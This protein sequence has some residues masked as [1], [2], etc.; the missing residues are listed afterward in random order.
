MNVSEPYAGPVRDEPL[1]VELHNTLFA[2]GGELV[3]GLADRASCDAW[4]TALDRRLP[5]GGTRA[6]PPCSNR[7]IPT[8]SPRISSR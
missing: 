1:A 5:P 3:D 4:L 8:G 2:H 7:C 6:G